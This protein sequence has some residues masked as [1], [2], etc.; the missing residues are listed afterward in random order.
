MRLIGLAVVLTLTLV[1][2]PLA[3]QGQRA[4]KVA[5]IGYL[6]P[7]S[8]A[9]DSSNMEAFRQGLRDLGYVEGKTA[10]IDAR[11]ADGKL[12]K[13]P[14]LAAEIVRLNVD[15]IVAAPTPN[16]TSRPASNADDPYRYGLQW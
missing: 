8:A 9:R 1:L 4:G 14:E 3:A 10:L 5:H 7:L 12:E 15:V 13:L 6:S 11:Y 2:A 16:G